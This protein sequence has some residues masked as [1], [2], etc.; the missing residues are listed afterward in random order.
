[1]SGFVIGV[2]MSPKG[3]YRDFYILVSQSKEL[4]WRQTDREKNKDEKHTSEN[5]CGPE[6]SGARLRH[7]LQA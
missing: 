1:M 6:R 5:G 3:T 7:N 2:D 4:D